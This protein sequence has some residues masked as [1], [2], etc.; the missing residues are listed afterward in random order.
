[1]KSDSFSV[2]GERVLESLGDKVLAAWASAVA[3]TADDLAEYRSALPSQA[4]ANGPR[5]LSNLLHDWLWHH[6]RA[7][8]DDLEEVSIYEKGP[9]RELVVH[10]R[11][12][13]R[14]KRHHGTGAVASYPTTE[15]LRFYGQ[16]PPAGQF[17]LFDDLPETVNLVFGYIWHRDIGEIGAATVSYPT[18]RSKPLWLREI[19]PDTPSGVIVPSRP[20]APV[21]TVRPLETN[22]DKRKDSET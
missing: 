13:I 10:D 21:P 18:S 4:A 2:D 8:T 12:R 11:F 22:I 14:V 7:E 20:D 17:V 19:T 5:G 9:I 16:H 15:A 1:M 3:K 6:L